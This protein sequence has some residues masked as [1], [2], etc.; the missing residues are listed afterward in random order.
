[1]SVRGRVVLFFLGSFLL[2]GCSEPKIPVEKTS[3]ILPQAEAIV[4]RLLTQHGVDLKKLKTRK[5]ASGDKSFVR[6]EQR[7]AVP[8]EFNTLN[9]NHE[10]SE[11]LA[12]IGASVVATEKSED[13]TVTMHIKNN[14]VIVQSLVFI[15][16]KESK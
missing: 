3:E 1:M 6:I 10:L 11:R 7:V 2:V 9:F 15:L 5:V 14:G 12:D 16:R 13:K 4:Q 8:P